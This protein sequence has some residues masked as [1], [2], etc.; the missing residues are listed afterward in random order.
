MIS[1]ALIIVP[2]VAHALMTIK[3]ANCVRTTTHFEYQKFGDYNPEMRSQL[4]K[5]FTRKFNNEDLV[6]YYL[7]ISST[8][9]KT[10]GHHTDSQAYFRLRMTSC[11]SISSSSRR[12]ELSTNSSKYLHVHSSSISTHV[13]HWERIEKTKVPKC[14]KIKT[15]K[16]ALSF[17]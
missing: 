14:A 5:F 17:A 11:L 2:C 7:M 8:S 3:A 12:M 13:L 15:A 16:T 4:A 1:L 10:V 9:R 6:L